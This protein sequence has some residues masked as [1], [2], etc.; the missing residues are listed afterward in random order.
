MKNLLIRIFDIVAFALG[1]GGRI[2]DES[3]DDALCDFGG[4][5]RDKYGR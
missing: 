3:V 5:G 4:Q 1:F 2:R